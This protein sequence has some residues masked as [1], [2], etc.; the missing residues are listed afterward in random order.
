MATATYHQVWRHSVDVQR[1]TLD[2]LPTWDEQATDQ[3]RRLMSRD[4]SD[5]NTLV[6]AGLLAPVVIIGEDRD[7]LASGLA[8]KQWRDVYQVA[9]TVHEVKSG[10]WQLGRE[11]FDFGGLGSARPD[12]HDG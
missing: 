12:D 4:E 9:D 1:H 10:R 8:Y 3:A 11:K 5:A 7:I 6:L 2:R